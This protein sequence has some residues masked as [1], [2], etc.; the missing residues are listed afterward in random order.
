[1]ALVGTLFITR[2]QI[3]NGFLSSN[4]AIWTAHL[5]E[6]RVVYKHGGL[7]IR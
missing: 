2:P 6:K 3:F 1:M 5:I 4:M 7:L